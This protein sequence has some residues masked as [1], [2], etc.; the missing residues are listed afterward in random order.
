MSL[1]DNYGANFQLLF[2][3]FA[4]AAGLMWIYGAK[5]FVNDIRTMLGN[6]LVDSYLFYYWIINWAVISPLLLLV[7]SKLLIKVFS[8]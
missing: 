6:A 4:E 7:R 3:G 5:R 8:V 2:Y 1:L